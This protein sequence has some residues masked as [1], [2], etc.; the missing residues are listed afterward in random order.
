MQGITSV[1]WNT[2]YFGGYLQYCGRVPSVLWEGTFTTV[3]GITAVHVGDSLST[4]GDTFST[5]E[6]VHYSGE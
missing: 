2:Q 1:P 5:V 4:V 6:V 3:R